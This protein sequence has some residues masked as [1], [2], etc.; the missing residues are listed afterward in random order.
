M[1]V[2]KPI[3]SGITKEQLEKFRELIEVAARKAGELALKK[4]N[5]DK[6]GLQCLI[7][8]GDEF[9]SSIT[10]AIIAKTHVLSVSILLDDDEV[11]SSCRYPREYKGPRLIVE[12]INA[13]ADTFGLDPASA[14]EY[15]KNLPALGSFVPED[16]LE[17]VGWFAVLSE[18]ALARRYF[19]NAS[20]PLD[21]YCRAVQLVNDKI[22]VSRPFKNCRE[23]HIAPE[24]LHVHEH[25]I[26][27]C[28][29]ITKTQP[30]DIQ[31]IAAQLGMRHRARSVRKAHKLFVANEFGLTSLM[32]GSIALT[33]PERFVYDGELDMDCAGDTCWSDTDG[34]FSGAPFYGCDGKHL[35]Y[36]YARISRP[37]KEYGA[38]TG[39]FP[40]YI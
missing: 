15:A 10:D 11:E 20:N 26:H 22:A 27:A 3:T 38:S 2:D 9:K 6:D 5:P 13:L 32:G 4:V 34:P 19:P 36:G 40:K 37:S 8:N 14:L 12:Q 30:G 31:I 7:E 21:R 33:H 28:Q 25:T 23:G 24:Y 1:T 17:W 35:R 18:D 39:F 16:A 29:K